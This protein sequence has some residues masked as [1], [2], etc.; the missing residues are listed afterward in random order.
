MNA[1]F[2]V[3]VC[4]IKLLLVLFPSPVLSAQEDCPQVSHLSVYLSIYSP[5][6]HIGGAELKCQ[7]T[8]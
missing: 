5:L 3:Q 4:S 7:L 2:Y 8:P 1:S 6:L